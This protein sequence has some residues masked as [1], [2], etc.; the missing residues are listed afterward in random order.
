MG[1][2]NSG[3]AEVIR[4]SL[5]GVAERNALSIHGMGIYNL[6]GSGVRIEFRKQGAERSERSG[7]AFEIPRVYCI[8]RQEVKRG[9]IKTSYGLVRIEPLLLRR[10]P[11]ETGRGDVAIETPRSIRLDGSVQ[12]SG[13]SENVFSPFRNFRYLVRCLHF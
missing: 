2:V 12:G 11:E 7:K 10:A 6:K 9:F 1:G 13:D 5:H 4:L 8:L 3:F